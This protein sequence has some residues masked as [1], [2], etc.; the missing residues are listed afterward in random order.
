MIVP[1]RP[2]I[3]NALG[4]V[5]AD[6]RHDFVRTVNRPVADID[7][8]AMRARPLRS[9]MR[10]NNAQASGAGSQARAVK[11]PARGWS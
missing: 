3:T 6:L 11:S 4:C 7:E 10:L 9:S 2:G 1:A 5:V 8:T